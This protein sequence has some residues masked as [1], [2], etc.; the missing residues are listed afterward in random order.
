[1]TG[2]DLQVSGLSSTGGLT[3]N[4]PNTTRYYK[5]TAAQLAAAPYATATANAIGNLVFQNTLVADLGTATAGDVYAVK[6]RG[7]SEVMLLRIQAVRS[8]TSGGIG[9]VK[10]EYRS[11]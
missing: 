6:V 10:F 2:K 4:A 5:L 7:T 9:R 11:L 3:L 1:V 8:S